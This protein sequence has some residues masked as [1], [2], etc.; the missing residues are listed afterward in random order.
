[1]RGLIFAFRLILAA[2]IVAANS[3][4]ML[5]LA[6]LWTAEQFVQQQL[7]ARGI[8]CRLQITRFDHLGLDAKNIILSSGLR[9][10][11]MSVAW[12]SAGLGQK[13][14]GPIIISGA[15]IS[16]A[17]GETSWQIGGIDLRDLWP[18][19]SQK[20]AWQLQHVA[21]QSIKVQVRSDGELV[22]AIL[23]LDRDQQGAVRFSLKDIEGQASLGGSTLAIQQGTIDGQL[24]DSDFQISATG[25]MRAKRPNKIPVSWQADQ[26]T[27]SGTFD[28]K[29]KRATSQIEF[30][31]LTSDLSH[32]KAKG[33]TLSAQGHADLDFNRSGPNRRLEVG[34][35]TQVKFGSIDLTGA[36]P[37]QVLS[38]FSLAEDLQDFSSQ[39][40]T[41]L[42]T[43]LG[44]LDLELSTE[45]K[46]SEGKWNFSNHKTDAP[47]LQ[48]NAP[49]LEGH[50]QSTQVSWDPSSL[51][52]T[53]DS[54]G[55][56]NFENFS[57]ATFSELAIHGKLGEP[58]ALHGSIHQLNTQAKTPHRRFNL[59]ANQVLF[60][61]PEQNLRLGAD[62]QLRWDGLLAGLTIKGGEF[63]GRLSS[64][65]R[66]GLTQVSL[67]DKTA[68]L[69][70]DQLNVGAWVGQDFSVSL[71]A[72]QKPALLME[73]EQLDLSFGVRTAN[74]RVIKQGLS[75]FAVAIVGQAGQAELTFQRSGPA[76]ATLSTDLITM[77]LSG[78]DHKK[79]ALGHSTIVAGRKQGAWTG[80]GSITQA[81]LHSDKLPVE[82]SSARPDF[83]FE[84]R[85]TGLVVEA[86]GLDVNLLPKSEFPNL[87]PTVLHLDTRLADGG[88]TGTGR[89]RLGDGNA[90]LGAIEFTHDLASGGGEFTANNTDLFF[91][92][93]G[94]QPKDLVP[95]LTGLVANVQGATAYHFTGAWDR[96][97]LT[98]T[99]G[100][101][102]L[103]GLDFD[104]LLGRIEAVTGQIQFSSLL[105][106]RTAATA[107]INI[108]IFDPGVALE[109]GQIDFN[110]EQDGFIS[111]SKAKWP[112][113]DG[114][115]QVKPMDWEIGGMDQMAELVL[116]DID[117]L[118]LSGIVGFKD[119]S[120]EGK[121]SGR[122]PL[123]IAENTIFVEQAKLSAVPPGVLR[124]TGSVGENAGQAAPQAQMAFDVLKNLHFEQL[125]LTLDGDVAGRMNAG[126]V[127]EGSNPDVVYGVPFLLRVNTSAEFARLA[128]QA[129]EGLRI[130]NTIGEAMEQQ[131]ET[132]IE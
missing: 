36:E 73:P 45:F 6:R 116:R 82:V 75:D 113:A 26:W 83:S 77:G 44:D 78:E 74:G 111:I 9:A 91:S 66:P 88:I 132:P 42:T 61:K 114:E 67:R 86:N 105:P 19:S 12:T 69:H 16:F 5:Y 68:N 13:Q 37:L 1:M 97:G 101:L 89:T 93:P 22:T 85:D 24:V 131:V 21:L 84:L 41:I 80:S 27:F 15:N 107:Q 8:N 62:V 76:A 94:L 10:D 79:I 64:T 53:M 65:F 54:S 51:S 122:I 70:I 119:L 4:A 98:R 121:M 3:A 56:L 87:P 104:L 130:A 49:N 102:D 50:L 126:L 48:L 34:G 124:Y 108:G 118:E 46:M 71:L 63:S 129:T 28:N 25:K 30:D 96:T 23:D 18:K 109:N 92:P 90:D 99:G 117:L 58:L 128:R 39:F 55:Q 72:S 95:T 106:L 110:L 35:T 40:E 47:W 57:S 81:Q 120:A 31:L 103:L 29:T 11:R 59:S 115:M 20:S 33:Q 32:Q 7:A 43:A 2:A 14:L 17:Q 127:I 60:S 38:Q 112:F 100:D 125:E 52:F 123:R